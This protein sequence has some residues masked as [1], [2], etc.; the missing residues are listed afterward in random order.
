MSADES[1]AGEKRRF[2]DITNQQLDKIVEDKD[3]KNTKR[4]TNQAVRLFHKYLTEQ[5]LD[6]EFEN[7]DPQTLNNTLS[8]LYAEARTED[9]TLYKKSSLQILRHGLNRFLSSKK[10]ID[11]VRE[12]EFKESKKVFLVVCKDLKRQGFGGVEHHPP[13]DESDLKKMS[14]MFD[15]QN[16]KYLQ[17]RVFFD[18]MLYFGRRG[19]ENLR[20]LKITDFNCTNDGYM[21][22][23]EQTKNHQD[24]EN[25]ASGQMY[26]IQGILSNN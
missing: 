11:I 24:D 15:L 9:G 16:P 25:T 14:Q 23:D 12:T 5:E 20:T 22:R 2:A 3:A 4:S 17:W 8:K 21:D 19:R 1:G 18:I 10:E 26:E 7:Y 6:V 13:I